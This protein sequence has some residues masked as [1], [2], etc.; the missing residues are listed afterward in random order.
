M[1]LC[2]VTRTFLLREVLI[3]DFDFHNFIILYMIHQGEYHMS[4]LIGV[5]IYEE[6]V[7]RFK[8]E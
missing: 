4:M 5:I 1:I 7:L 8:Y 3:C 6:L 2:T